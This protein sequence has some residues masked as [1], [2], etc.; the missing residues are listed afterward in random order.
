MAEKSFK[1]EEN[2]MK[3]LEKFITK[4]TL[5][6]EKTKEVCPN[7]SKKNNHMYIPSSFQFFKLSPKEEKWKSSKSF[8]FSGCTTCH[9]LSLDKDKFFEI[10]NEKL[11]FD[12]FLKGLFQ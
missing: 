5:D 7:C 4:Q 6:S 1:I 10:T 11:T 3:Y 8:H 9:T 2:Q 12:D